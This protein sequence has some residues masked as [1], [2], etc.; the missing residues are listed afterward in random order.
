LRRR[1][2]AR[3]ALHAI[4]PGDV[5]HPRMEPYDPDVCAGEAAALCRDAGVGMHTGAPIRRRAP[6]R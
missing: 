4:R 2:I 1:L 6:E 3:K 5:A